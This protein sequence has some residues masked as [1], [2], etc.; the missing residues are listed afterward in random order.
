M[1]FIP[2]FKPGVW[3]GWIFMSVFILQMLAML[4]AGSHIWR[5]SHVP[6]E[7]RRSKFEKKIVIINNLIWLLAMG[8]SIFLPLRTGTTWF[9]IGLS[10]FMIGLILMI[11][12]TSNFITAPA[13]QL[14]TK[15]AYKFSRNPLYLAALLICM[16]CG[17]AA[18][19]WLFIFLSIIMAFYF[20]REV[21]IEERYCLNQYGP[22]Y[23]E[24]LKH[25]PRWLGIPR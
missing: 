20:H 5:K 15:G 2:A 12:A 11:T 7:V 3:N 19:S 23:Q 16:G 18:A 8:Y 25:V 24:Y 4:F 22:V 9:T 13:N 14:I 21:L 17:M 6:I 1:T 10:L